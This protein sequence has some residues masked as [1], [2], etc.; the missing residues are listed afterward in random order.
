MG[1]N[2][3]RLSEFE[4][5]STAALAA[6]V[7]YR[8]ALRAADGRGVRTSGASG[9]ALASRRVRS[10]GHRF[11]ARSQPLWQRSK[12]DRGTDLSVATTPHSEDDPVVWGGQPAACPPAASPSSDWT[13]CSGTLPAALGKSGRC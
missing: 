7:Q 10:I 6:G 13:A 9:A 3:W 5:K 12:G 11:Y 8:R 4:R 1:R 2:T